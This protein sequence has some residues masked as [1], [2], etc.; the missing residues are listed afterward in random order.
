[1]AESLDRRLVCSVT[2]APHR[3]ARTCP[4]HRPHVVVWLLLAA[5][6]AAGALAPSAAEPP[7]SATRGAT[8]W[9]AQPAERWEEALPLGNGRMGAMVFG[10]VER[11]HLQLN[12]DTLTSG[13]PPSDLRTIRTQGDFQRVT[14]WLRAG[15]YLEAEEYIN[16]HWLQCWPCAI[17]S[18]GCPVASSMDRVSLSASSTSSTSASMSTGGGTAMTT[19][20]LSVPRS[21]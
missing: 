4:R 5:G 19:P 7:A 8:L 13:E 2:P 11:E 21:V 18:A 10:G 3:P 6:L 17:P 14:A 16:R 12:E 9:Y 15:H 1:M 20:P